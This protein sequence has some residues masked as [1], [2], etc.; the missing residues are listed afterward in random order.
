MTITSKAV[1]CGLAI[2]L[3]SCSVENTEYSQYFQLVRQVI[4]QSFSDH[5]VPLEAVTATPYASMGWRLNDGPEDMI[6]LATDDHG[7]QIWTSAAKIVLQT[8]DGRIVRTVGL[9]RDILGM[10]A[11]NNTAVSPPSRALNGPY[12]EN[13]ITD[14]PEAYGVATSCTAQFMGARQVTILDRTIRTLQVDEQCQRGDWHFTDSYW[15]DPNTHMVWQS[16]QHLSA[17]MVI[18]TAILRPPG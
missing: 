3:S 6:V 11:Q 18:R 12:S 9:G 7:Q 13:R 16:T 14:F 4:D 15:L 17:K 8:Q 1:A 10:T 5:R 2:A